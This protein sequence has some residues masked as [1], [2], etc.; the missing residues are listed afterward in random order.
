MKI[1][2]PVFN[3]TIF[4]DQAFNLLI[5]C[6]TRQG[7]SKWLRYKLDRLPKHSFYSQTID[8]I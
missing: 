5:T 7:D 6:M 1:G 2:K 8:G 4:D 3:C